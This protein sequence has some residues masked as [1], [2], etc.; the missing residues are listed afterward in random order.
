[1]KRSRLTRRTALRAKA[2]LRP[3]KPPRPKKRFNQ[4]NAPRL[5]KRREAE[6]GDAV[7]FVRYLPCC[8]CSK[9][10]PNEAHHV[11]SRAAG[12]KAD[13]IVALCPVHHREFHNAGRRTFAERHG[14]DLESIAAETA[15]R[16][17]EQAPDSDGE[18]F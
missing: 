5:A 18:P 13:S 4:R 11:R 7:K 6:F 8:I 10:G 15:R 14:V 2:P 16:F 1:M 3:G 12:G 9:P 17:S